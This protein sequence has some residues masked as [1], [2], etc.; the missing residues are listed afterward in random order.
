MTDYEILMELSKISSQLG[1]EI[2]GETVCGKLDEISFKL[3]PKPETDES[4]SEKLDKVIDLL[5]RIE[6]KL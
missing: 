5:E 4:V 3:S 1:S 6:R 2:L